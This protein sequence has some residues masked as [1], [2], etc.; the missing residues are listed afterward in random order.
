MNSPRI[1]ATKKS[2]MIL[3]LVYFLKNLVTMKPAIEM[4]KI[5]FNEIEMNQLE[6]IKM[7]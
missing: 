3:E 7:Y 6:K 4:S 1:I 2:P 5:I